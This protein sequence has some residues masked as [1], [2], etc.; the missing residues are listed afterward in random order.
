MALPRIHHDTDFCVVGGGIAGMF[1]AISAARHGAKVVLMH[2][3]PVLGGN[4]SSEVRMWICGAAGVNNRET[5]L[6]EELNL[7]NAWRNPDKLYPVWDTLRYEMVTHEPN[8][9]LLLNCSCMD[10]ELD[11]SPVVSVTRW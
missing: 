7:R 1:A 3:R 9:E 4:A 6:L 11:G 2:E 5:G 10:A 8:I